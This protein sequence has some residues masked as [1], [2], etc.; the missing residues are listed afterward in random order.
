MRYA[1]VSDIH[2]NWQAW[3][4]VRDD[5]LKREVN[6]VVCL[7]D[8]IG[9]GPNPAQVLADLRQY[10][11]N[12]VLGNHDSAVAGFLDLDIFNDTARKA[13]EWTMTQV[14]EAGKKLLRDWPLEIESDQVLFVHAETVAPDAYGYVEQPDDARVC[15]EAATQPLT[16]LGHTHRAGTF[17]LNPNGEI[18]QDAA[19]RL[20]VV[21]GLRYIIN[22]GSVGDPRDGTEKASYAI[23]DDAAGQVELF[24][25]SFDGAAL[26]RDLQQH[27]ELDRPWFL[28]KRGV[29]RIRLAYDHAVNVEK[30]AK[31]RPATVKRS[32]VKV[33]RYAL[34]GSGIVP[35][36]PP[37]PKTEPARSTSKTVLII[38]L[39]MSL[40]STLLTVGLLHWRKTHPKILPAPPPPIPRVVDERAAFT[41]TT[42]NVRLSGKTIKVEDKYGVPNI[43][44]W[45]TSGDSASWT[46][47]VTGAGDYDVELEYA[48]ESKGGNRAIVLT[49][50]DSRLDFTLKTTVR[51]DSYTKTNIGRIRLPAGPA[52]ITLKPGVN[53]SKS[54]MNLRLMSFTPSTNVTVNP[55]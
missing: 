29:G 26:L 23:F 51:W 35:A 10:C 37:E 42:K 9:Y 25:V 33:V 34:S 50:G 16:F 13:A 48:V 22:V 38:V 19:T 30:T 32:N 18:V 55:R 39:A 6:A 12:L 52:T 11:S 31:M 47:T 45:S 3:T 49:G 44:Y 2:A 28:R 27:P 36:A 7:G 14:D 1:I 5:F 46:T 21:N 8:V 24:Q 54:L 41:L 17:I 20:P 4:A 15:F 53:R 43:G 40:L